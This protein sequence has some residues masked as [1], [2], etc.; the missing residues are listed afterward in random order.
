MHTTR[1]ANFLNLPIS[2]LF[3]VQP[4]LSSEIIVDRTRTTQHTSVDTAANGVPVVNIARPNTNGVSHNT[5][6]EFNVPTQGTILN[7]S[8]RE[9]NT[10]LAGYIYGNENVRNGSASLI[11]N[12]VSGTS[13]SRLNGYLEVAGQS[14][15][16]IVANPNGITVNGAGFINIPKA[17]LTTGSVGFSGNRPVYDI[18]GGDIFIDGKGLDARSTSSLELYTKAIKLNASLHAKDL[19]MVTGLNHIDKYGKVSSRD[20]ESK[21]RPVFS[22]DSTA[23]GG[24]YANAISLVGTQKGVGVNLPAEMLVQDKLEISADGKIILG[25]VSVKNVAS[26][27][28]HSNSIEIN[29]GVHANILELDAST[30]ITLHGNTGATKEITILGDSLANDGLL[31]AGVNTDFTQATTGILSLSLAESIRNEGVLYGLNTIHIDT[32]DFLNVSEAEVLTQALTLNATQTLHNRG[33]ISTNDMLLSSQT[34][35]NIGL[36]YAQGVMGISAENLNNT[37]GSIQAND[38]LTVNVSGDIDNTRGTFYSGTGTTITTQTLHNEEGFIGSMKTVFLDL[39][40]LNGDNGIISGEGVTIHTESIDSNHATI[41]SSDSLDVVASGT[42]TL[43]NTAMLSNGALNFSAGETT[44]NGSTL[45]SGHDNIDSNTEELNVQNSYL[46]ADQ[47]LNLNTAQNINLSDSTIKGSTIRISTVQD[48][49]ADHTNIVASDELD[50]YANNLHY[51]NGQ[52]ISADD[53]TVTLEGTLNQ[54]NSAF[55]AYQN[56]SISVE[57]YT[58]RSASTLYAS[59]ALILNIANTLN[60][61]ESSRIISD[62]TLSLN[63]ETLNLNNASLFA[64]NTGNINTTIFNNIKGVVSAT[65]MNINTITFNNANSQFYSDGGTL[66]ITASDTLNNNNGLISANINLNLDTQSLDNRNGELEAGNILDITSNDLQIEGSR[67]FAQNYL[68]VTSNIS[69]IDADT[70]FLSANAMELDFTGNLIHHGEILANGTGSITV[71]GDLDNEGSITANNS[72]SIVANTLNNNANNTG[73]SIRGGYLSSLTLSGNL[74]NYGFLTSSGNL[75]ITATE[76]TNHAGIA[77]SYTLTLNSTDLYN[78]GTL[79]SGTDM[80]LYISNLLRN[81]ED[82]DIYAGNT[83]TIAKDDIGVKSN[84]VENISAKIESGGDMRIVATDISN[85]SATEINTV[86]EEVNGM[87]DITCGDWGSFSCPDKVIA[88]DIDL[89]EIKVKIIKENADNGIVL[90]QNELQALLTEE[91]I[92]KDSQAYIL[93]MYKD[94]ETTANELYF[95][96]LTAS[97]ESNEMIVKRTKP[98]KKEEFRKIDYTVSSEIVDPTSIVNHKEGQI[99]SGHDL[100]LDADTITNKTSLITA[101]NDIQ[102]RGNLANIGVG[103]TDS[104]DATINYSWKR[105]SDGGLGQLP[106]SKS[107][108][109]DIGG[110]PAQILAGGTLTGN[111][112]TLQNGMQSHVSVSTDPNTPTISTSTETTNE[113]QDHITNSDTS[114]NTTNIEEQT[115]EEISTR[116]LALAPVVYDPS[117]EGIVLSDDPYGLFVTNQ[118]P[119]GPIIESNPEYTNY[120][121]FVSSD[122]MLDRLGY[123][124]SSQTRRLGDAMYETQLIRDAIIAMTGQRYIGTAQND[125]DQYIELMNAGVNYAQE[126]G[127]KLG[128]P[129]SVLQLE[130]LKEDLVWMEEKTIDGKQV[131]VPVLYLAKVYS[132]PTGANIHANSMNLTVDG[133]LEN[134]GDMISREDMTLR[135]GSMTNN[136]GNIEAGATMNI[137]AI[138]DIK[139]LSGSI[140]GGSVVLSSTQG[141]IVNKTLS[142][143]MDLQHSVGNEH[144]TLIDKTASISATKGSIKLDAAKNIENIGADLNA[145]GDIQLKAKEDINI[146]TLEDERS[147]DYTFE[148]GYAK[149]ESV[150]HRQSSIKAGGQLSIVS[151]KN[152]HL[153]AVNID[154]GDTYINA[155]EK[156]NIAAV[157]DSTYTES[158]FENEGLISSSTTTDMKLAQNVQSTNIETGNL[159]IEGNK[160]VSLESMTVNAENSVQ[161]TSETGDIDFSSKAYTNANYHEES[162][163]TFGGLISERSVDTVSETLLADSSTKAENNIVVDGKDINLVATDLETTNGGIKLSA[164]QNVNILSGMEE[165]SESH[166]REES[167]LSFAYSDGRFTFAQETTDSTETTSYTNKA[168]T[169]KTNTLLLESGQDTNVIAS[170]ITAGSMRVDAG[171]DFNV[172]SDKDIASSNEEH[173]TK[174]IG[175]EFTFNERESSVFAGYWEDQV[176]TART[177]SEVVSSVINTGSLEVNSQS[178]NVLGSTITGENIVINSENI[179]ILSDSTNTNADTYT[180]A[181]KAGVEIAVR[182]NLSNVVDAVAEVGGA[183]NASAVTARGLR[184]YDALQTFSEQPVTAGVTALYEESSSTVHSM[185]SEVIASS[186]SATNSLT[187]NASDTLEI[188]GSDVGSGNTLTINANTINIHASEG[189]YTTESASETK[190]ASVGLYGTNIGQATVAYQ[191]NE[192]LTIGITQRNSQL[193]AGGSAT[194]T[195]TGDT[196]LSGA[197]IEAKDLALNVGGDLHM[198]SLQDTQTI[199][200]SSRGGSISGNVMVGIPTGASANAGETTGARAWVSQVTGINGSESVKVNVGGATTLTGASITNLNIQGVEQGNLE[201]NTQHLVVSDIKDIDTYDSTTAGV[202]VNNGEGITP[203]LNSVEYTNNTTDREQI[204]RATIGSGTIN[205]GGITGALNRDS[206]NIQEII[207]DESSSVELYVSDRSLALLDN[208]NQEISELGVK[209]DDIGASSHREI[210]DNLPSI[211]EISEEGSVLNTVLDWVS[212]TNIIPTKENDGGYITQIAAQ[213]SGDNRTGISVTDAQVLENLGLSSRYDS[214]GKERNNWDYETYQRADGV[215]AYRTNPDRTIRIV[216]NNEEV[217]FN[218][219]QSIEDMRIYV[220][221]DAVTEAGLNHIFTNGLNNTVDEALANQQQQQALP[222]IALLNYNQTHGIVGDLLE[223]GLERVTIALDDVPGVQSIGYV[224]NGSARQTGNTINQLSTINNGNVHIAAHS[225]GT[226]QTYLGLQQ[227]QESIAQELRENRMSVFTLQN[228]GAPISSVATSELVVDGLYGGENNIDSRFQNNLGDANV[229]RSQVNPGDPVAMLGGNFGGVNNNAPIYTSEFWGEVGYT[230]TRGT[231]SLMGGTTGE[232]PSPHSGYECVIGCGEGGITPSDIK[233]YY[234]PHTQEEVALTGFYDT[235]N[236]EPSHSNINTAPVSS[237]QIPVQIG[238]GVNQ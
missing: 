228:S 108:I 105:K 118:D 222:D 187:L 116:P 16:V 19:R 227:N 10:Q 185:N 104:I 88:L 216:E 213:L 139:N 234:E 26:I 89:M 96:E 160:G 207:R 130:N 198:Q 121:H 159:V 209:L 188:A 43:T 94:T 232:N 194:I 147:Y 176:E 37:E 72:L 211:D 230:M 57:D 149:G 92:Q 168:S 197:N 103:S 112:G 99:L 134:T 233:F 179:R 40:S 23:L 113:T 146:K 68:A 31:A 206:S 163:S 193:Y 133:H 236:V 137:A 204:T 115:Q 212:F 141:N 182:Q 41:Q 126:V 54:D 74:N 196:T 226:Q 119:T 164:T 215:T 114:V 52:M 49:T 11:L 156:V 237:D 55:I 145:K 64:Q 53:L 153:E 80:N 66:N 124:G 143:G 2:I 17:T 136:R 84:K 86:L 33:E 30:N 82:A 58:L 90:T 7:N 205:T 171:R 93:N 34:M 199:E 1:K 61:T 79:L 14:A 102:L 45:Y 44:L 221:A 135:T 60:I 128:V 192:L 95:Y 169:I 69:E 106:I 191:E 75:E 29:E 123:D 144:Y 91:M 85:I 142:R 173:S 129:P 46:E 9:V 166:I 111:F 183:E 38:T 35:S 210:L 59:N 219:D 76:I 32:K 6:I 12:E 155:K 161:I 175:V 238:I 83:L 165:G 125:N 181:I 220:S 162:S 65:Q 157:V 109:H 39:F 201:V 195:S 5:Y 50:I 78:H 148:N 190:N 18:E 117:A 73:A 184:A 174:E 180:H 138:G 21:E 98:H 208:P 62:N 224:V 140:K 107:E 51:S 81:H 48:V 28:S 77:A 20:S 131:L 8:G 167:G 15:D 154:A 132:K 235:I 127:L 87:I 71:H 151:D 152:I 24:I 203:S 22:I 47:T 122:Y 4:L 13:R 186:V 177:Q 27:K 3:I 42:V 202:G 158:H 217:V 25:T 100:L 231:T 150:E 229:F 189:T 223:T 63:A 70:K 225:Q 214:E 56:I 170:N 110:V 178:T 67:F 36:I 101:S 120:N 218:P 172:L 97:L 200:G